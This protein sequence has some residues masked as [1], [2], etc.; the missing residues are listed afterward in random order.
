MHFNAPTVPYLSN[1]TGRLIDSM[2][3]IRDDLIH[4][5]LYPV[6]FFDMLQVVFENRVTEFIELPPGE[7]LSN[8]VKRMATK[9]NAEVRIYPVSQ[10]G[11]DDTA[12]LYQKW[13]NKND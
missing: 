11:I 10:Y 4:N 8:I 5:V 7:V 2:P 12:Y 3:E 9:S 13:S 1:V 6:Q